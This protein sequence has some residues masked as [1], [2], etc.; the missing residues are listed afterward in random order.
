[1]HLEFTNPVDVGVSR[2]PRP[3]K[4][5]WNFRERGE[6]FGNSKGL[7]EA[8]EARECSSPLSWI[9]KGWSREGEN[10]QRTPEEM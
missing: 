9:V 4:G 3:E 6:E 2:S 10:V 1:M 8:A 5:L 7:T